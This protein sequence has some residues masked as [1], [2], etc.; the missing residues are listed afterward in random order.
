MQTQTQQQQKAR[1]TSP[2]PPPPPLLDPTIRDD[3]HILYHDND[4]AV[5]HKPTGILCVPGP[6]RNPSLANL[7]HEYFHVDVHVDKTVVHRLDMDTSGVVLFALTEQSLSTLH[8]DFRK[9]RVWKTYQAL[10]CGHVDWDELEIDLPLE[11]DPLRPPFMRVAQPKR[12]AS[13]YTTNTSTAIHKFLRQAPKPSW[14]EVRVISYEFVERVPVTRV[15]L[16][17]HT[18][19]THQLR[20]HCAAIGHPIVGDDIYGYNGEGAPNGGIENVQGCSKYVQQILHELGRPLCL[21][22]QQLCIH[23]PRTGAPM[24]F[25]ADAAF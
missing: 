18:G 9:G 23:H 8:D 17:P 24:I 14:T 1:A 13:V 5:V 16:R 4:I 6:R 10:L 2:Q 25:Q 12:E 7:V 19:R 20:V 15:Q 22:A 11:R 3:L 21:H